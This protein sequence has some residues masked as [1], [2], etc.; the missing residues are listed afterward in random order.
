MSEPSSKIRVLVVDDHGLFRRGLIDVLNEEPDIEVVG[1]ARSSRE[2]IER[3]GELLPDV[4]CMDL[5]M[6]DVGGVEASAYVT[7]QWPQIRVLVLTVSEE[8]DNLLRSMSVGAC[9]HVLKMASPREIVEALRQVA[10]GWVVISPSMAPRF[11]S[12]LKGSTEPVPGTPAG[13]RSGEAETRVTS[14]EEE[15]LRLIARGSSNADIAGELVLS[16]NTVKTHVKNILG[17]LRLKNRSE[18]AAYAARLGFLEP[19]RDPD[20]RG[21]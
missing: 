9:G 18:A 12:D 17:K 15:V 8:P 7:R 4:I 20:A 19:D 16:E 1:E 5:N 2:A 21:R 6:P 13:R 14:R 3:A 11:L 10:Q